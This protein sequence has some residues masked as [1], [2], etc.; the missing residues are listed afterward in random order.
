MHMTQTQ[1]RESLE[2]ALARQEQPPPTN[3]GGGISTGAIVGLAFLAAGALAIL[4][5]KLKHSG[6]S[7][8]GGS[9]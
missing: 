6:P 9:I 1:S 3:D 7:E 8:V 2:R 5:L 4:Y